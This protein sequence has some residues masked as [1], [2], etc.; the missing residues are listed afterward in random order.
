MTP[1]PLLVDHHARVG[2]PSTLGSPVETGRPVWQPTFA[3]PAFLP[4]GRRTAFTGSWQIK[5]YLGYSFRL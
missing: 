3:P 4:P 5:P 1:D 2:D